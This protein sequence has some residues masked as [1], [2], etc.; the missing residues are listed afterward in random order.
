MT[1]MCFAHQ[2]TGLYLNSTYD[3]LECRQV[4]WCF[5]R[6]ESVA[7]SPVMYQTPPKLRQL[8]GSDT[9][10]VPDISDAPTPLMLR[11][12]WGSDTSEAPTPLM[13]R[14][15]WGS[16]TSEA[17][18]TLML[19]QL[20]GSDNSEA[21]TPLRYLTPLMLRHLWGFDNSEA[22]TILVSFLRKQCKTWQWCLAV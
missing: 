11:H 15:L 17:P 3:N 18:T 20:W 8:W 21:P 22:P 16:G 4:M 10:E 2:Q 1:E 19:W 14:H 5:S 6:D 9:S 12:F 13:L 7:G